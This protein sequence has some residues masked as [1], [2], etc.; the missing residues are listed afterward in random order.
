MLRYG[1]GH[2]LRHGIG[3]EFRYIYA[4]IHCIPLRYPDKMPQDKMPQCQKQTKCHNVN[5]V[6]RAQQ[7]CYKDVKKVLQGCNM[8]L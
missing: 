6:I 5:G 1:L 3:Y 4:I 2:R 8:V 7:K